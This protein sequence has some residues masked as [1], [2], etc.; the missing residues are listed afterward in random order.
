[1]SV[2]SEKYA[3]EVKRFDCNRKII[4][5]LEYYIEAN[6]NMRFNQLLQVF[7]VVIKNSDQFYEESAET[8]QRMK[9]Y[10]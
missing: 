6:P 4:K 8:L 1:M 10:W 2:D 9:K 5:M 3:A 7:D